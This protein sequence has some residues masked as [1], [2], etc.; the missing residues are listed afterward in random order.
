MDTSLMTRNGVQIEG[1]NIKMWP[2]DSDQSD[3]FLHT[4]GLVSE[5]TPI[6]ENLQKG[7]YFKFEG[8]LTMIGNE[9]Y[10]HVIKVVKI[11]RPTKSIPDFDTIP[12]YQFK[13]LNK[14][15]TRLFKHNNN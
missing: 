1:M 15:K 13:P 2:T 8:M 3:L 5:S 4:E 10:P 11:E 12:A 14:P 6:R 9:E 7:D